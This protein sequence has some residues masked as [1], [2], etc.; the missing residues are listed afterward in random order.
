MDNRTDITEDFQSTPEHPAS[1][2]PMPGVESQQNIS[3]LTAGPHND[4]PQSQG[5]EDTYQQ[6]P[7]QS[8]SPQSSPWRS[9]Q[10]TFNRYPLQIALSL[11]G[12][13]LTVALLARRRAR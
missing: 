3:H 11:V 7:A 1:T 8:A 2:P 6:L 13:G 12:L 4:P 9:L 10:Q 5:V